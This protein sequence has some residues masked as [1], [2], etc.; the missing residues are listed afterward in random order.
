MKML[1]YILA[2]FAAVVFITAVVFAFT[3]VPH[4]KT[5]EG[6]HFQRTFTVRIVGY[7]PRTGGLTPDNLEAL[8]RLQFKNQAE[9]YGARVDDELT[10][11]PVRE[12]ITIGYKAGTT[13]LEYVTLSLTIDGA[14]LPVS[15]V[16]I[17][18][19]D[20]P[21]GIKNSIV[22]YT[23]RLSPRATSGLLKLEEFKHRNPDIRP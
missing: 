13:D 17:N 21:L 2:A 1:C 5:L 12:E 6:Y 10:A 15:V 3:G 4:E 14:E 9:Y 7:S 11:T 8:L 22:E 16:T 20:M 23:S 18:S 19:A